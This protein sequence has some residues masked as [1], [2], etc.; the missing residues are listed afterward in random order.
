M[1]ATR[2]GVG[3]V[4]SISVQYQVVHDGEIRAELPRYHYK[5]QSKGC[6]LEIDAFLVS[7]FL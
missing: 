4:L 3:T 6:L 5:V 7:F 1:D 2:N